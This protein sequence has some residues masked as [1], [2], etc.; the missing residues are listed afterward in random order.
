MAGRY[1]AGSIGAYNLYVDAKSST[2]GKFSLA[3]K[4]WPR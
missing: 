1:L 3:S 4:G 2:L